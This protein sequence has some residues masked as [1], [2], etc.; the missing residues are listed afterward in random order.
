M[1]PYPSQI[2]RDSIV[3]IAREMIEEAGVDHLSLSKLASEMGVKAPSLYRYV[4]NKA[5]L[6]RAVNTVTN[7]Q[8]FD[9]M[10]ESLAQ[11]SDDPSERLLTLALSYRQFA[12]A[13]PCTYQLLFTTPDL[14]P[15][16]DLLVQ[17]VLPIQAIMA[18]LSGEE[19]SLS[20][21]RGILALM[22]GFIMLELNDQLRR[23]GNLEEAYIQAI[24][25][26]LA[27]VSATNR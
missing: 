4:S 7:G 6:I 9:V 2:D 20:A 1:S 14:R 19:R 12:H 25:A 22:H 10:S 3:N 23:G 16:E 26:Y 13:N 21:L 5:E 18:E 11:A 17:M 8:L 27:G 24:E 15:D